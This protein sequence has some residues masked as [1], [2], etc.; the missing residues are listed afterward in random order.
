MWLKNACQS[1]KGERGKLQHPKI[2]DQFSTSQKTSGELRPQKK[3]EITQTQEPYP[4]DIAGYVLGCIDVA[5]VTCFP[6]C[7]DDKH[8]GSIWP[9]TRL[10]FEHVCPVSKERER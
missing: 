10:F 9:G 1:V 2:S 3:G 4:D 5:I 8:L 7:N 6:V